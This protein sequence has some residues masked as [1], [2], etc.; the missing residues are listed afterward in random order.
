[1]GASY[2]EKDSQLT[3]REFQRASLVH[4][5][6]EGGSRPRIFMAR[7][8]EK[9]V[10]FVSSPARG[11]TA[12]RRL[13]GLA[14]FDWSGNIAC[15]PPAVRALPA[16]TWKN[17]RIEMHSLI[18]LAYARADPQ[19]P[20]TSIACNYSRGR[21]RAT[22]TK[23]RVNYAPFCEN[24]AFLLWQ[25]FAIFGLFRV[26]DVTR[27]WEDG[28]RSLRLFVTGHGFVHLW[29]TTG[30]IRLRSLL[31]WLLYVCCSMTTR[32]SRRWWE[33]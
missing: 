12:E 7:R 15:S 11:S 17:Y 18:I 14:H 26:K 29:F 9:A 24:D 19:R 23:R 22:W 8:G 28:E 5:G 6:H 13:P 10:G 3:R 1:M 21:A 31:Y 20:S 16:A 2:P 30:T 33:I 27:K 4:E 25:N 32:M